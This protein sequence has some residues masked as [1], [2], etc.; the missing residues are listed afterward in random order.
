MLN[1]GESLFHLYFDILFSQMQ[2]ELK[3]VLETAMK[4]SL[5][6]NPQ[7]E[8]KSSTN[9]WRETLTFGQFLVSMAKKQDL[10]LL[11]CFPLNFCFV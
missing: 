3:N 2:F 6:K 7:Q 8:I 11:N 4:K 1:D 5:I 10:L 9:P